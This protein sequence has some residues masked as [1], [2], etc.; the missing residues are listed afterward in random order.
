M[1]AVV[2]VPE[3]TKPACRRCGYVESAHYGVNFS[4]GPMVSGVVL[5][6]PVAVFAVQSPAAGRVPMMDH[7]RE[8][9]AAPQIKS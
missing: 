4:D 8:A 7:G 9:G 5:I 3:A 2:S 1:T 6:C